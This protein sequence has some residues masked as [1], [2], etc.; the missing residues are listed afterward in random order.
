[1]HI[2]TVTYAI[3]PEKKEEMR[4]LLHD[5][6]AA[7]EALSLLMQ[8]PGVTGYYS[9]LKPD[10]DEGVALYLY[11]TEAQAQAAPTTPQY[12]PF[13]TSAY[14]HRLLNCMVQESITRQ[15]YEV[16]AQG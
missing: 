5:Q 7:Q 2:V 10:A 6:A 11:A 9:L 15:V 13:I 12:Q 16:T 3:Q 1:M 8:I 14:S 4:A